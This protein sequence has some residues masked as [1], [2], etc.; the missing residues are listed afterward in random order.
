MNKIAT[1][2]KATLTVLLLL[3]VFSTTAVAQEKDKFSEGAA[4]VTTQMKSK[5][6]LN[7]GQY[8]K[9]LD[10]NKTFLQQAADAKAK[11]GTRVVMAKAMKA[12]KDRRDKKLKSVL[13]STQ[14]KVYKAN[15]TANYKKLRAFY[16]A[17]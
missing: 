13:N 17:Q 5:L 11:G 8:T 1:A 6:S 14:Y 10:I 9:V 3:V 15:R 4:A 12:I 16:E 7:D 2:V